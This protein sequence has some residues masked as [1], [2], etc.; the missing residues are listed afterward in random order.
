MRCSFDWIWSGVTV[1]GVHIACTIAQAQEF[2]TLHGNVFIQA[3][4]APS[5]A[6]GRRPLDAIAAALVSGGRGDFKATMNIESSHGR[7]DPRRQP[8]FLGLAT[9]PTRQDLI[10]L[11]AAGS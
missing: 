6:A 11:V 2:A 10:H 7:P 9:N 3:S 5:A 8:E 4:T 1:Q